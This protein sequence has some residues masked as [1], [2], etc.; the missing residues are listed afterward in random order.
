MGNFPDW[1]KTNGVSSVCPR[2]SRFSNLQDPSAHNFGFSYDALSRRTQMTRPNGVN[3]NY[4][5]DNLSR[6]LSV[7][8]Q[9]GSATLDGASYTYDNAGNRT[10][11]TDYLASVTSNYSFDNLYQLTQVTQGS[12]TTESYSY[13]AVGNRL[14]SL[15]VSPYA[16]NSSNE[17]T[18][19]PSASYS[20]D[21]NGNTTSKTDSLGAGPP[22]WF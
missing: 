8:H 3:S 9:V 14:S 16:Y 17:L 15:G 22:F 20:Y 12:S 6:L 11:K 7:L 13:D 4:S 10:A 1:D 5:Y 21:H 18:S 19:T 2:F